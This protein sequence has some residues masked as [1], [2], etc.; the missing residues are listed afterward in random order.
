MFLQLVF[1]HN[2][3]VA[4]ALVTAEECLQDSGKESPTVKYAGGRSL[5][6]HQVLY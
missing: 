4:D 6:D 2:M 1:F 3:R 5:K